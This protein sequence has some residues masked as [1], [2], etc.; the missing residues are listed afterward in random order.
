[1][2]SKTLIVGC[3][4][5]G[6]LA[7]WALYKRQE[8]FSVY[9]NGSASA[10]K[11]AAGMYNPVSFK[12]VVEVW[13]AEEHMKVMLE[14]YSEID[15]ALGVKILHRLP[16]LRIFPNEQYRKHWESRMNHEVGQ[17]ISRVF[18]DAPEGVV[19]PFGFGIVEEAGWVNLPEMIKGVQCLMPE[20]Y[21]QRS[22]SISDGIPDGY[23]RV[24][25]CRGVGAKE[26]IN[27]LGY[28]LASDHGEI[29]TLK[30]NT[31]ETQDKIINTVKWLMPFSEDT[32]KLG[33]TY[34]WGVENSKPTDEGKNELIESIKPALTPSISES[35][36]LINHE[37]GL[38]PTSHD[39]R[40]YACELK[41]HPGIYVLNGLGTR[42]V[43][44]APATVR[45]VIS[46]ILN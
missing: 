5:A 3:G 15:K 36:E 20:K 16:I 25:D 21:E 44:V 1:M 40:P 33:A 29:I 11:V 27:Q 41:S 7:A 26:E 37:S 22:W 8:S 19:A 38:R 45:K 13:N 10:S 31:L 2:P 17:W 24:I 12:R 34:E 28:K 6:T 23:D 18:E 39:R 30:S 46:E 35:L 43:L 4:L 14:T 9:D 42:G 32:Y